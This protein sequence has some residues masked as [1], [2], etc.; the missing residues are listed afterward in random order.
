[1]KV[2]VTHARHDRRLLDHQL[3]GGTVVSTADV[4]HRR[5]ARAVEHILIL[6][7]RP[8]ATTGPTVE[9]LPQ[10]GWTETWHDAAPPLDLSNVVAAAL[11]FLATTE[12][13]HGRSLTEGAWCPGQVETAPSGPLGRL[14]LLNGPVRATGAER[15]H[16]VGCGDR[17]AVAEGVLRAAALWWLGM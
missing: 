3:V 15:P 14:V 8:W 4:P 2:G 9:E 11:E 12:P 5:T 16:V 17:C 13:T 6:G 7:Y 10:G 1:M